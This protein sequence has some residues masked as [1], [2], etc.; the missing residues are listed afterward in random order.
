MNFDEETIRNVRKILDL[1]GFSHIELSLET[2]TYPGLMR[3]ILF[4]NGSKSISLDPVGFLVTPDV[5]EPIVYALRR[6]CSDQ[7]LEE[8][9]TNL[10]SK[11]PAP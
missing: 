8:I 10:R 7:E 1:G 6:I 4:T 11:K 9:A 2:P 3:N 5:F